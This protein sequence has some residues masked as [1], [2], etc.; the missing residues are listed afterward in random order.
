MLT[1]LPQQRWCSGSPSNATNAGT[2]D[3]FKSSASKAFRSCRWDLGVGAVRP[4]WVKMASLK[5]LP[6][7]LISTASLLC[8]AMPLNLAI[9]VASGVPLQVALVTA[10]ISAPFA[11]LFGGTTLT[12]S[13]PAAAISVLVCQAVNT[14][15]LAALPMITFGVG[16]LQLLMGFANAGWMVKFTP[17]PVIAGFTT[18][19]GVLISV[20]QLPRVLALPTAGADA[21]AFEILR[22][23]VSN[24]GMADPVSFGVAAASFAVVYFLPKLHPKAGGMAS[25]AAVGVGTA[26][27][28]AL[29]SAGV[30]SVKLVGAMPPLAMGDLLRL[31]VATDLT[32]LAP[33]ILLLF[34]LT[35]V[36]S[37]LS[38]TAIDKMRHTGYKH[39]PGGYI[40]NL[41]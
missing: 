15:G 36:E 6:Q 3:Y 11:A 13:G 18:G 33:T 40:Q 38:C 28:S 22:H 25:L 7:D 16:V 4:E 26:T 27:A 14:H 23:V 39:D 2:L 31:P 34:T 30:G 10:G 9:A 20:G 19:V 41:L 8:I 1:L 17:I 29:S 35:S 21:S 32:A 37:L 5:T 24:T 12:V